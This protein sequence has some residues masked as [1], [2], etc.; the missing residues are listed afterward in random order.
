MEAWA[1]HMLGSSSIRIG[2]VD[3]GEHDSEDALRLFHAS[4]DVAGITLAIDDL[5][6][7]A[8]AR[9]DLPRAARLWGA[10]RALSSA[11]GILLADQVDSLFEVRAR[12][13]ARNA[14]S[15]DEL[16]TYAR[17]GRLMSVDE[18]VA[19]ALDIHVTEVPGPHEHAGQAPR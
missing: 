12:P 13:N 16:E 8:V 10:A 14:M 2:E 4:G 7:V 6:S 9:G 17:E 15:P 18:T 5:A 3:E 1:L 11:G 19:Y